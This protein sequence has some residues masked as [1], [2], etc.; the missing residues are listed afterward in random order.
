MLL[1]L[2][3]LAMRQGDFSAVSSL[4]PIYDPT[5]G[6]ANGHG[7]VQFPS[8]I[9][10]PSR[11]DPAAARLI[12]LLPQPNTTGPAPYVNN[13]T[14]SGSFISDT[15][16][17]DTRIDYDP[18]PSTRMFGAYTFLRSIY[19]AP[20]IFGKVL[21]GPG[22]G[23]QAEVG[24]TRTQNISYTLTHTFGSTLVGDFRFG[25]SRFR[26]NLAQ[27]DVGL[28]TAQKFGIPG[29]NLGTTLTDGLPEFSWGGP[30]VNNFFLGN[31]YA[32]F[33][34]LEQ[35]VTYGTNW[36]KI[37]GR[38][39]LQWGAELRPKA[40]LQ[41]IDKSLRGAFGFGQL[42]TGSADVSGN[43][44]IGF[45][46]FLLGAANSFS[47]GA[48]LRL[49]Q[50]YQ[51]R[52]ATYVQ[53]MWRVNQKLAL[54]FGLR[55]EYFSPTYSNGKA[56]E[57]V[58]DLATA[59]MV[60]AG[61]GPYN[62]Y[63]GIQPDY[64]DFGPRLGI[65]YSINSNTVF[66][67]GYAKSYAINA[68]GA[69]F[70]SYCCQWPIGNNQA[71]TSTTNYNTIFPLEQGPP[72][73]T[74]VN[75]VIPPSGALPAPNNQFLMGKAFDDPTTS[76]DSWNATLQ[77]Q[78]GSSLTASIAYVADVGRHLWYTHG[79]NDP[80]PGPGPFCA[81]QPYCPVYGLGQYIDNRSDNGNSAFNSMQ[82]QVDK[83]F[84]QGYQ[85]MA[86]YT[87]QKTINDSW[88]NPFLRGAYKSLSG[89]SQ[90]LTLSHVVD[91]P[92]GPGHVIGGHTKGVLATLIRDW[93]LSGIWQFQAGDPLS[94]S[95]NENTLNVEYYSQ[96]P[97]CSG[98]PNISNPTPN[99]WFDNSV[100][101]VPPAYTFGSCGL[102]IIKGPRWW[103]TDLQLQKNFQITERIRMAFRWDWFN[104]FNIANLGNPNTTIDAPA[105]V[106]GHI[107]DVHHS[108][109]QTQLGLHLYF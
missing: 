50:D 31:P 6:D 91:L 45:A 13:Y 70:G 78:F 63:A 48:Y 43:T 11:I 77:H 92:F 27:T 88:Q 104:A 51:D 26:S 82:V 73:A 89:P 67:V 17:V 28:E 38:H 71:I 76:L 57:V 36:T 32:N 99:R 19:D 53:D 109:R 49:P 29:I 40:S 79:A 68:F 9:I 97:N 62:K 90:W 12:A 15:D 47:R 21:G 107:F 66:R 87:W 61:V 55:W 30:I 41:R 37:T 34:E 3:T 44:G 95:M 65:A 102:S 10:P 105:S 86:S 4:Y 18:S 83:R 94:P 93:Q 106:V 8:N 1:S 22:F 58:F 108:M 25:L 60:F 100:F 75:P 96:M 2:P 81:R 54:T 56:G 24:G 72:P 5:T 46:S 33:Y 85:F 64:R 14:Q 20:P 59:N 23:P 7:R 84:T 101:S 74:T 103:N 80:T 35:S 52:D 69:N 42:T 39:T 16:E 98:N